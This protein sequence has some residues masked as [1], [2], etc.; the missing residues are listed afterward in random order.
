[1]WYKHLMV[2]DSHEAPAI[3]VGDCPARQ[4]LGQIGDKWTALVIG[5]LSEG[6]K[7]FSELRREICG[8][9]QKML[10]QTLRQLER[11]GLV[12]RTIYAEVPPR[13]EY[14]LTNVG[15][16]LVGP[17]AVLHEWAETHLR[18]VGDAQAR[19]DTATATRPGA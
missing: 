17:I 4:L 2:T 1:M 5:R 12:E 9:S 16:T 14:E 10:T 19:Y 13:V 11:N 18:D 7:R 8:V 6:R 15:R 3:H